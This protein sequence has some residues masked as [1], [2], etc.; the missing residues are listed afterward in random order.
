MEVPKK[1]H[2]TAKAPATKPAKR[3]ITVELDIPTH[4]ALVALAYEQ[5]RELKQQVLVI[6][7]A[8]VKAAAGQKRTRARKERIK[9][10]W[11][12]E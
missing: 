1:K 12:G 6:L 3:R 10:E 8:A 9:R 4:D 2:P 11:F 5:R 7:E